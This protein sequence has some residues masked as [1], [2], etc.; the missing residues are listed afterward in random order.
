MGEL[1]AAGSFALS[2]SGIGLLVS[3]TEAGPSQGSLVMSVSCDELHL[4]PVGTP[5][6]IETPEPGELDGCAKEEIEAR[7]V[8]AG[9][10]L[11]QD[12]SS[13]G[14]ATP[15]S[16]PFSPDLDETLLSTPAPTPFRVTPSPESR[17]KNETGDGDDEGSRYFLWDDSDPAIEK[18]QV[19]RFLCPHGGG[20]FEVEVKTEP[21]PPKPLR[22]STQARS[23]KLTRSATRRRFLALT[24]RARH[25]ADAWCEGP[26]RSATT[27]RTLST[28]GRTRRHRVKAGCK[29]PRRS[30]TAARTRPSTQTTTQSP[31]IHS[32][33]LTPTRSSRMKTSTPTRP[34]GIR[35]V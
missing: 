2:V 31:G 1:A 24:R 14:P 7:K 21:P 15:R 23:A 33:R 19:E 29:G 9:E 30:T 10:E 26:C 27:M 13:P 22:P 34:Q 35:T 6:P 4:T 18:W 20:G 5:V 16:C 25:Q 17:A 11:F 12:P 32:L 28:A 8:P 3:P